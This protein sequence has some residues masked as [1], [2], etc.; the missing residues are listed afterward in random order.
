MKLKPNSQ[1]NTSVDVKEVYIIKKRLHATEVNLTKEKKKKKKK[2]RKE[3]GGGGTLCFCVFL[4]NGL[5]TY[6]FSINISR[7]M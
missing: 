7:K 3:K 2:E 6:K 4:L 5:F 1:N